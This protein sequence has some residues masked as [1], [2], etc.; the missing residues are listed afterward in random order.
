MFET[1]GFCYCGLKV[2][3]LKTKP[4]TKTKNKTNKQTNK[5]NHSPQMFPREKLF[6]VSPEGNQFS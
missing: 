3:S 1:N 4:K 5:Q 6:C 2:T